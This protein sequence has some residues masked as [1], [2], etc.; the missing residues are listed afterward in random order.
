M[1]Q[2]IRFLILGIKIVFLSG[3]ILP[4]YI[5]AKCIID[6]CV[7]EASPIVYNYQRIGSSF[8]FLETAEKALVIACIWLVFVFAYIA[9]KLEKK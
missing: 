7:L 4:L 5:S 8:P 1:K 6:W 9:I 3:W 2:A